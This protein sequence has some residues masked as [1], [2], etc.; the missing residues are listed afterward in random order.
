MV[1]GL[2]V[3]GAAGCGVQDPYENG[4]PATKA[5]TAAPASTGAPGSTGAPASSGAPA[6]TAVRAGAVAPT[7]GGAGG[8]RDAVLRRF[9]SAWANW[10][11]RDLAAQRQVL[12]GLAAEPLSGQLKE[13]ARHAAR[14]ALERVTTASSTGKMMGSIPQPD[15]SLVVVTY[16]TAKAEGAT[17]G[18]PAYHVYLVSGHDTPAGWRVSKWEPTS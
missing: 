15:G 1:I 11:G 16:E 14:D 18:Q 7:A 6:S 10:N 17:G 2:A 9:A 13:D 8:G 4:L 3:V 12:A 5:T